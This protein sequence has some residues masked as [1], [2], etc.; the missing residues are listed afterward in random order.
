MIA[1]SLP[2]TPLVDFLLGKNADVN[3]KSKARLRMER[4]TQI[5]DEL[6]QDFNGQVRET[7]P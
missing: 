7:Q 2:E 3:M 6:V 4:S 5:A 1:A